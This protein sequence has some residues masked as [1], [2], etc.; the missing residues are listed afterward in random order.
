MADK[1]KDPAEETSAIAGD[2]VEQ[3]PELATLIAQAMADVQ[4]V[5]KDR[6]NTEHN[7]D[8]ASVEAMKRAVRVPLL[9]RGVALFMHPQKVESSEVKSRGGNVGER[10][11]ARFDFCFSGHGQELTVAGWLGVGVDYSDKAYSK[12]VTSALKT[13]INAQWMLPA[14]SGDDP[15]STSPEY[16]Q[17]GGAAVQPPAWAAPADA[18]DKRTLVAI[19]ERELGGNR[20]TAVKYAAVLAQNMGGTIPAVFVKWLS[21]LPEWRAAAGA[22]PGADE[23]PALDTSHHGD[24]PPPPPE[25]VCGH[26]YR[27]S[28]TVRCVLE[29]GHDGPHKAAGGGAWR[30]SIDGGGELVEDPDAPERPETV[31]DPQEPSADEVEEARAA[32]AAQEAGI[33]TADVVDQPPPAGMVAPPTITLPGGG[34]FELVVNDGST[35]RLRGTPIAD[36]A[37]RA[38]RDAG[39]T[40]EDPLNRGGDSDECPIRGH[41][42]PF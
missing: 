23:P 1:D 24:E 29:E 40:C 5:D 3:A 13:F 7:Y 21:V 4:T 34:E 38:L 30:E 33:E 11:E 37:I 41:G 14:E 42:I 32:A 28:S 36:V 2:V 16:G 18:D 17:R 10:V 22:A 39:C 20:E 6:R 35:E 19:L 31:L 12:A 15:D 9:E 27:G 25:N 8:Y 26:A